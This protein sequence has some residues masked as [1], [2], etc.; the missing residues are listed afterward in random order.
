[1]FFLMTHYDNQQTDEKFLLEKVDN[2]PRIVAMSLNLGILEGLKVI[3]ESKN[4]AD[5][6]SQYNINHEIDKSNR[7]NFEKVGDIVAR[8][9]YES[10]VSI[11]TPEEFLSDIDKMGS[12]M[13]NYRSGEVGLEKGDLSVLTF[14][15]M[16]EG[17][18]LSTKNYMSI[19][20]WGGVT[21]ISP[22]EKTR[23]RHIGFYVINPKTLNYLNILERSKEFELLGDKSAL[24]EQKKIIYFSIPLKVVE[25]DGG[26]M[27]GQRQ[28]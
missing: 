26:K 11:F 8:E 2:L 27:E 10:N 3:T 22:E 25:V 21:N 20:H 5:V 1:M 17:L 4:V 7:S 12:L 14:Y 28:G 9:G 13:L 6:L 16:D 15:T 18:V 19:N 23:M 24:R